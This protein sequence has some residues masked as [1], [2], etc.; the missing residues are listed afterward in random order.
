MYIEV[1]LSYAEATKRSKMI[2]QMNVK[3]KK[4]L[5]QRTNPHHEDLLERE[6]K[7]MTV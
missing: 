7:L 3:A 4:S 5:I 6:G 2:N 1:C